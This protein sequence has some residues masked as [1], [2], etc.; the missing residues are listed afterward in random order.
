MDSKYI[1]YFAFDE[2]FIESINAKIAK[3]L[4]CRLYL[5]AYYNPK[6]IS[7][8]TSPEHVFWVAVTNIYGFFVDCSGYINKDFLYLL[9][10]N[11]ILKNDEYKKIRKF[12]CI[13]KDMR[14]IFCHN[15]STE[16]PQTEQY[17]KCFKMFINGNLQKDISFI[18]IP[19]QLTLETTDWELLTIALIDRFQECLQ[20]LDKS[21][22][23]IVKHPDKERIANEWISF[24]VKWYEN[25]VVF[26]LV[27]DYYYNFLSKI[28]EVNYPSNSVQ[29]K[30][31]IK[32]RKKEWKESAIS[33]LQNKKKPIFP[34]Q[35]LG[36]FFHYAA[37]KTLYK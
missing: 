16:S 7:S 29:K 15:M 20:I 36:D 8:A 32:D 31:W 37:N 23:E 4:D 9:K 26:H 19:Y 25:S 10:Q 17:L 33:Y 2:K 22:T 28:D 11:S 24:I 3:D 30:E 6:R 18:E 21:V 5:A 12:I 35:I 1:D 27:A 14:S 34:Y 13:V